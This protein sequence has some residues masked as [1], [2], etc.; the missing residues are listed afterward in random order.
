M[1]VTERYGNFGDATAWGPYPGGS[2]VL[3]GHAAVR[4]IRF[5]ENVVWPNVKQGIKFD[6]HLFD[7]PQ[8]QGDR[9]NTKKVTKKIEKSSE[10]YHI[11]II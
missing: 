11:D 2:V 7:I 9:Y 8:M 6:I 5:K 1:W 10:T 3:H 4:T